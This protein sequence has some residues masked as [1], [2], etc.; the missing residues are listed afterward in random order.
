MSSNQKIMQSEK[1]KIQL[2]ASYLKRVGGFRESVARA[3]AYRHAGY[4]HSGIA[5]ELDTN[6]GTVASWMDRVAAEYG[7]EA[8]ETKSV[9]AQPDLEEMTTERLDDEYS[10][11]VAM[12]WIEV[13]TD[14]RDIVP[15][16]L[17][18]RVN[19]DR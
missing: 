13:A 11:E 12:D 14:Y 16:E 17:Q 10:N 19:P 6:E 9:G 8:I 15:D 4:S 18:E 5:K 3:L 1:R 7:F 2:A